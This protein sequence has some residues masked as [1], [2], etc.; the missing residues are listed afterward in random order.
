ME[1]F[2]CR[3]FDGDWRRG[4]EGAEDSGLEGV[5]MEIFDGDRR[6]GDE[7]AED[8]G[9]EDMLMEMGLRLLKTAKSK[10]LKF[11]MR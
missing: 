8:N 3:L 9:L 10:W 6:R 1:G 11:A 4:D 2:T 7:G 5:S